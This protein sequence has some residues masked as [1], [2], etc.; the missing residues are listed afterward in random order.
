GVRRGAGGAHGGAQGVGQVLDD[1][2][3]LGRADAAAAGDHDGGLGQLGAGALLL[4]DPLDDAGGLGGVGQGDRHLLL[5]P[6]AGGGLGGGGVGP[7][8]HD[9]DAPGDLGLDVDAAAEDGLLGHE[10]LA[11]TDGVGDDAGVGLDREPAGDLLALGG[12]GD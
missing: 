12:G 1:R 8:G 5:G 11:E 6:G 3:V 9:R 10:A 7:H 4:L 2:E